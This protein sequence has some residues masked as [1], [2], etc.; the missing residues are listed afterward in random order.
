MGGGLFVATAGL[1]VIRTSPDGITWTASTSG[2][3]T[4][5]GPVVWTGSQFV[6]GLQGDSA[7][8][9]S[10]DGITWTFRDWD[11]GSWQDMCWTGSL[12]VAVNS[13]GQIGTSPDGITWT[14]RHEGISS[15]NAVRSIGDTV[16][17]VGNVYR[18]STDGG[19][20]WSPVDIAFSGSPATAITVLGG[21][22]V[23]GGQNGVLRASLDGGTTWSARSSGVG[24]QLWGGVAFGDR[25]I[26]VGAGGIL[27]SNVFA[28]LAGTLTSISYTAASAPSS[29]MLTILAQALTGNITANTS[30]VG[31]ISRDSG[32]TY[33]T[34][35]LTAKGTV[36]GFTTY[37]ATGVDLSGQPS[38]TAM[39]FQIETS[40]AARHA[41][42]G[43][44]LQWS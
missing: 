40:T 36:A 21:V 34:C 2:V 13:N 5:L 33:A 4:N 25:M 7:F 12:L 1:G 23:I 18:R 28:S 11:Y 17:A 20:T 22:I 8:L 31:K 6:I 43:V 3:G 9:T 35:T 30:L 41:I 39:R 32:T 15:L 38:G 37:E 44:A 16:F 26:L 24:Y 14:L 27:R 10:P 29:G 42:T 19:L